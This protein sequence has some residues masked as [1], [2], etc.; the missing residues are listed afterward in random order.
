MFV[1]WITNTPT[2]YRNHLHETMAARFPHKGIDFEVLYMAWTSPRRHWQFGHDE[3]AYPNRVFHDSMRTLRG[4]DI[5]LSAELVRHVRKSRPD[6]VVICGVSNPTLWLVMLTA[7]EQ[8]TRVLMAESNPDSEVRVKGPAAWIKKLMVRRASAYIVT[9]NRASDYLR[10]WNPTLET[11]PVIVLPNLIDKSLFWH[12]VDRLRVEQRAE[13]RRAVG[14]ATDEQLWVC[15]A[16]LEPVKGLEEFLPLLDGVPGV[17]L[18]IAGT[19]WLH[20]R[21]ARLISGGDLP[22]S[23]VGQLDEEQIVRLYAAADVFVLPSLRDPSPLSPI[24]ASAA[25]LPLLLSN[26][27]GN[28]DDVLMDGVNGWRYDPG[29]PNEFLS[30][31]REIA[32]LPSAE[33]R[34]RGALSRQRYQERFDSDKRVDELAMQLLAVA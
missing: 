7:G 30:T 32:Q 11:K 21:L 24:E 22:V 15:P 25:G 19:G 33:L 2:P 4:A 5:H 23:L 10:R 28:V 6:V 9:G 26:R 8:P 18:V 34:R 20:D 27:L 3:L 12:A 14:V 29:R 1:Q 16:R 31:I 17:R 13:L